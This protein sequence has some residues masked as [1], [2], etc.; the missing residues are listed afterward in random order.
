M[1]SEPKLQ[2]A[3]IPQSEGTRRRREPGSPPA[4]AQNAPGGTASGTQRLPRRGC[5][6]PHYEGSGPGSILPKAHGVA[7]S[8]AQP[9]HTDSL[10]LL[11]STR[12]RAPRRRLHQSESRG[13]RR[14]AGS[15]A[16]SAADEPKRTYGFRRCGSLWEGGTWLCSATRPGECRS[17]GYLS[18]IR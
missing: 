16:R 6:L 17:H 7:R 4:A 1:G 13:G 18:R 2:S 12:R 10:S 9:R 3:A 11:P 8:P 14:A 5:N 15:R